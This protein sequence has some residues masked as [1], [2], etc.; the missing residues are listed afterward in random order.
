MDAGVANIKTLMGT[1][2]SL[3]WVGIIIV[4]AMQKI[5]ILVWK[6]S[7]TILQSIKDLHFK[8]RDEFTYEQGLN[9][10]V[11]FTAFDNEVTWSLDPSYGE[12]VF[13]SY[14]WGYYDNGQPYS[15]RTPLETH[16]CTRRQLNLEEDQNEDGT[17][18]NFF[19]LHSSSRGSVDFYW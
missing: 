14:E 3:I 13:N 4:Y 5:D 18:A 15:I 6:K 8:D 1:L 17:D 2:C 9:V 12:L 16:N 11:A 7:V 19:Q 10:A